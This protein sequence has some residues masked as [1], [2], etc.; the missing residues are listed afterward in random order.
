MG[1]ISKTV[2]VKLNSTIVKWYKDKGYEIPK[3]YNSKKHKYFTDMSSSIEVKVSDLHEHSSIKVEVECDYCKIHKFTSYAHYLQQNHSGKYFCKSCVHKVFNSGANNTNYKSDKTDDE[4]QNDRK[5]PEYNIFIKSVLARDN[6]TCQCCGQRHGDLKV[7]HLDGYNW[8]KEKRTDVTNGITLCNNCHN[9][10]HSIYGYG[11][12]NKKQFEEWLCESVKNL[13]EYNGELPTARK[14]YCLEDGILYSSVKEIAEK[15]KILPTYIY[16]VCAHKSISTC[17][18]HF[19][20][21][22]EYLE[23]SQEEINLIKKTSSKDALNSKVICITTMKIFNSIKEAESYYNISNIS[24]C[25]RK[26]HSYAGKLLNGTKLQWAYY[27]EYCKSKN[28]NE[29][30]V[31]KEDMSRRRKVICLTTN[32]IFDT[33]RE[34]AKKYKISPSGVSGACQKRYYYYG[35]LSDSTKLRWMYY[36]EYCL[37]IENGKTLDYKTRGTKI[38][39]ITTGEIFDTIHDGAKKYNIK[40]QSYISLV[41]KGKNRKAGVAPDGTHLKWMFYKDFLTLPS[42]KQHEILTRNSELV[43]NI[44]H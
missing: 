27:D 11:D 33:I 18:R 38:I 41:C 1:L 44:S 4:R 37:L 32:E 40:H 12:N 16:R 28:N 8:C 42:E 39:C 15:Y 22:E 19:L 24:N 30:V 34:A 9:N 35:K 5:Y 21:E 26:N 17:G 25:C 43:T 10:F 7:H 36:D 29:E 13:E 31:L 20:Y 2:K 6:Y 14:V 3:H 23:K